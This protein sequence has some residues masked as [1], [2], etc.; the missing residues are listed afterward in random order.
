VRT[1]QTLRSLKATGLCLWMVLL[2]VPTSFVAAADL[3]VI[4]AARK[5]GELGW[6]S[7]I[8]Q[9]QSQKIIEEFMKLYPFIK[10]TYWR[11]GS[12]GLHNKIM[13]EARAG[14]RA[15]MWCR[16]LRRNSSPSLNSEN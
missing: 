12:V 6:W 11:S 9:D 16:R 2:G 15:G 7:T 4:E 8:A 5:E 3:K 1:F 13:I 10:A 14:G